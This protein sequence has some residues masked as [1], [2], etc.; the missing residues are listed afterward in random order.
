MITHGKQENVPRG[1]QCLNNFLSLYDLFNDAI[2][3]AEVTLASNEMRIIMPPG[4]D[5]EV[6]LA[7]Y[8]IY[9]DMKLDNRR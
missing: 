1:G 8:L 4:K 5:V 3:I 6:V 9:Q 7:F 2:Q